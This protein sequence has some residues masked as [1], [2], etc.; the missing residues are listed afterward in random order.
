M[1]EVNQKELK[2]LFDSYFTWLVA[3]SDADFKQILLQ[4]LPLDEDH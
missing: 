2:M 4:Q 3:E 1:N